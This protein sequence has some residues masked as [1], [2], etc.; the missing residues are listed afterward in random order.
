MGVDAR[1]AVAVRAGGGGGLGLTEVAGRAVTGTQAGVGGA[2]LA[3]MLGAACGSTGGVEGSEDGVVALASSGAAGGFFRL[4]TA[5]A[6]TAMSNNPVPA[7]S[8]PTSSRRRDRRRGTLRG[9]RVSIDKLDDCEAIVGASPSSSPLGEAGDGRSTARCRAERAESLL[10]NLANPGLLG[11]GSL[12]PI[13]EWL[14][15]SA[16]ASPRLESDSARPARPTCP[17]RWAVPA[18][19]RE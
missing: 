13:P 4:Q 9:G 19:P 7:E 2:A 14:S 10:S 3:F 18:A 1:G 8:V 12:A 5:A 15:I 11:G 6:R 17:P 16:S